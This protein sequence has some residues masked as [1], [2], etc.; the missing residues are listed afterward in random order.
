MYTALLLY[1]VIS[2]FEES[3]VVHQQVFGVQHRLSVA[4][5]KELAC[6]QHLAQHPRREISVGHN[7]RM[8]S[9]CN[10]VSEDCA[11]ARAWSCNTDCQYAHWAAHKVLCNVCLSV[12]LD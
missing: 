12:K 11:C 9:H 2:L 7:F 6:V 1:E 8:C 3:L 4:L 5:A 10:V